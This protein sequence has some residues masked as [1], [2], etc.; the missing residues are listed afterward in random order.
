VK[1]LTY[2]LLRPGQPALQ[3]PL[4]CEQRLILPAQRFEPFRELLR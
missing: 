4:L 3:L 1:T 2:L